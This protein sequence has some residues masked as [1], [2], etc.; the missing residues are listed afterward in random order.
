MRE[1]IDREIKF[2]VPLKN[3]QEI[4]DGTECITKLL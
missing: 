4:E 3:K 2:E 1:K